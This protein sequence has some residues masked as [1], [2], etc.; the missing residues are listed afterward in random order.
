[1]LI[2]YS[3][4]FS[5]RKEYSQTAH[6]SHMDEQEHEGRSIFYLLLSKYLGKIKD[7]S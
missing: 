1:M 4:R 2:F 3:I 5:S 6:I 7:V